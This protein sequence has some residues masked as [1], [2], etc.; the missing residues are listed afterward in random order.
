MRHLPDMLE[1]KGARNGP[2]IIPQC[3]FLATPAHCIAP[4]DRGV[5]EGAGKGRIGR[6]GVGHQTNARARPTFIPLPPPLVVVV[7][8][9][10]CFCT[11]LPTRYN[12]A[13]YIHLQLSSAGPVFP[14]ELRYCNAQ[15][16]NETR[17]ESHSSP[18]VIPH[19]T[20]DTDRTLTDMQSPHHFIPRSSGPAVVP[21]VGDPQ[22]LANVSFK[23]S[24]LNPALMGRRGDGPMPSLE[25]MDRGAVSLPTSPVM[26]NM[27]WQV[28]TVS[29]VQ[30]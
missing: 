5:R 12:S 9:R 1:K 19:P 13:L 22:R 18:L 24:R 10:A 17:R 8:A 15:S 14:L 28:S 2:L 16:I 3:Y 6:V 29:S 25:A 30:R 26:R 21:F 20:A 7:A 4:E 11:S 27:A 23:P